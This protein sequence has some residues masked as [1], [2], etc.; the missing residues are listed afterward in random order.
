[1][2]I[3][4]PEA[5]ERVDWVVPGWVAL[6]KITFRDGMR[7]PIPKLV[8][9]VLDHYEIAPSQLMLNTWR[10]LM[11]FKCLSMRHGVVC[12]IGEVLYSYYLK[13]H[14]TDK[15]QYPLIVQKD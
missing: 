9:D 3:R 7:L 8:W 2:G 15:G 11:S 14:E 12:E 1:M 6:Y 10:I 4:A 5:Y 13:E